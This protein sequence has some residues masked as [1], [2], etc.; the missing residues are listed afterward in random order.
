M[1]EAALKTLRLS[2]G[3]E[4]Q[5]VRQ[6]YVRLVRRYPPEHF[7]EQFSKIQSAYLLL[8]LDDSFISNAYNQVGS[9]PSLLEAAAFFRTEAGPEPG[10]PTEGLYERLAARRDAAALND[11]LDKIDISSI[12]WRGGGHE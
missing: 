11:L 6:A 10:D 3:A 8:T 9:A 4:P 12:E 7:P 1:I 2:D 5:E